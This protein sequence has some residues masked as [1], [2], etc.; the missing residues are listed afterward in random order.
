MTQLFSHTEGMNPKNVA[1][2]LRSS[3]LAFLLFSGTALPGQ[4]SNHG[5]NSI[6]KLPVMYHF[7]TEN[8]NGGIQNWDL[9][10]DRRGILYV[11]NN[12]GLLEFDGA[13]WNTHF[14][15][16]ATRM[17]SVYIDEENKIYVGGQNQ[18]GFF[19]ANESGVLTYHSLASL[20]KDGNLDN[21]WKILG[22]E[23]KVFFNTDKYIYI[24]DDGK[25]TSVHFNEVGAYVFQVARR[26]IAYAPE[27]GL[28][29]WDGKSFKPLKNGYKMKGKSVIEVLPHTN[30][31][32]VLLSDGEIYRYSDSDFSPWNTSV[33]D[34]FTKSL[35]NSAVV[36]SNNQIAIGTQNNG[37][38]IMDQKGEL[39]LHLS[40]RKGLA[41]STVQGIYEDQF[42]N[43][44]VG[45]A[46]G[47][48]YIEWGSP[49]SLIDE[50]LG[51]PGTGYTALSYDNNLY[52][53]TNNGL[54]YQPL[55]PGSVKETTPYTLVENSEGQVY[56]IEKQ[57]KD[58]LMGH[59]SGG[60]LVD[61]GKASQVVNQKGVWRFRQVNEHQFIA[62][63]YQGF[64]LYDKKMKS[65]L[66]I[67]EF[68]ESSRLFEFKNGSILWMSH[69]FKGVYKVVFD[70]T[71]NQI[72]SS[73]RYGMK[74]G[75][76]SDI[77]I[78]IFKLGNRLIFPA[79]YGIYEYNESQNLFVP[80]EE[81]EKLLGK[82]DH[83]SYLTSDHQGNI[84]F[85]KSSGLGVLTRNTFNGY[86]LL[87]TPFKSIN[88]SI[89]DNLENITILD[90]ENILIGAKEGFIHY[91][92]QLV[93]SLDVAFQPIIRAI[94]IHQ[95]KD[96]LL[97][98]GG[99]SQTPS[100]VFK[101]NGRLNSIRFEYAAPFFD[102]FKDIR[103][104][105]KLEN[106]NNE[107]S[108]WSH[109]TSKEYTNLPYGKYT[110]RVKAKNI[111]EQESKEQTITIHII[112]PW[113]LSRLAYTGYILLVFTLFGIA[114][115]ILD[116]K[117]RY[118]KK[119]MEIEQRREILRK[120]REIESVNT[121]SQAKISV[122]KNEKLKAEVEHKNRELAS[123]T[124]HLLS[125]NQFMLSLKAKLDQIVKNESAKP[126]E[127]R[128]IIKTIDKN[129]S[130]DEDWEQFSIHFDNV[131]S[132]F[133]KKLKNQYPDLTPQETKLAAYLRMNLS[134]KDIAQLLNISVRGVEIS[135]Y[136]LRKKMNLERDTNLV[137]FMM[138]L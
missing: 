15:A 119:R 51:V 71:Y 58:L 33:G 113:Y 83:I 65:S 106:F 80:N 30:G 109:T 53:G 52:L 112:P 3:L 9:C 88:K 78:N 4:T 77:L 127:I 93:K 56:S 19:K 66:R 90:N 13:H 72:K 94:H 104:Q 12:L 40:R 126:E 69:G 96:S 27:E 43:L 32:L 59:H 6:A 20:I 89:S 118:D 1:Q 124:M 86:E 81:L 21:V 85:L 25:V 92:P 2:L 137:S 128:K 44:W 107:W 29:E 50:R 91:N 115:F 42:H 102:G 61:G 11:A 100:G 24:Y 75:F 17:L 74:E 98:G 79:E 64:V 7:N 130:E 23:G 8:Y 129:I 55:N 60:F 110:F 68:D 97:Y 47:I 28:L 35:I 95:D 49:F 14:I 39:I 41:S 123:S 131:H 117:H 10:Q 73:R 133:L 57:G 101:I 121:E 114:M 108:E 82:Y 70:P 132:D 122:L 45:L 34:F 54:F 103:Y 16:N 87:T 136:R 125:K 116:Y 26:L 36:L 138:D 67:P 99:S 111:Y 84:Y 62:G 31:L 134:S 63:T 46:N 38:V 37:L 48:S 5:P 120:D 76:P 135:R 105:F 18:L 22:F